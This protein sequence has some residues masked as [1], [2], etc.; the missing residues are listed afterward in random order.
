MTMYTAKELYDLLSTVTYTNIQTWYN[1]FEI[2]DAAAEICREDVKH[3][4][5][6]YVQ[7]ML[8]KMNERNPA[9][10]RQLV[11]ESNAKLGERYNDS[12]LNSTYHQVM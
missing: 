4:T 9:L 12:K 6:L 11:D 3:T 2:Q 5:L 10:L 8:K 7:S 1:M